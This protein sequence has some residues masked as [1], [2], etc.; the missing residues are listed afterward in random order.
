MRPRPLSGFTPMPLLFSYG[1]LQLTSVQLE[2]FGRALAGRPDRLPGFESIRIVI[3]DPAVVAAS[4]RA[5]HTNARFDGSDASGIDGT[6]FEVSDRELAEAD[7]YEA[8]SDY[9]RIAVTLGSGAAAWIY[10][11]ARTAPE[12]SAIAAA[13]RQP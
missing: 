3:D 1:T 6:V 5:D 11:Y 8:A 12:P 10:L 4:G 7:R 2:T 9:R 13:R